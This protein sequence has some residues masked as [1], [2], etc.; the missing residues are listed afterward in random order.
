MGGNILFNKKKFV[1]FIDPGTFFGHNELEVAYLTWFNR[2]FIKN[3]FLEK[4]TT[5]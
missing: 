4:D 5:K 2:N 3:G 1:G